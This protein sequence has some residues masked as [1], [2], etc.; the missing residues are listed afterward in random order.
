V[1]PKGELPTR[2]SP[3]ALVAPRSKVV[4][5]ATPK[6]ACT[7]IKKM[8]ADAEGTHRPEMADR[9]AIMHVS[10]AQTI[11]HPAVHGLQRLVDLPEREQREILASPEWVHIAGLRDPVSRA[12]SAWENRIF[13][14][15]HRRSPALIR[16]AHDV[17]LDGRVD[18]VASFARFAV[19][20]G[21]NADPFMADHHFL[22]QSHV[23]RSDL[24]RIDK[25]V[26]VD[27][28]GEMDALAELISH[29]SGQLVVAQRLN[30]GLGLPLRRV[31]DQHS[32]NRLMATYHA[33]YDAFGFDRRTFEQHLEPLLLGDIEQR[34][35]TAYRNAMER[36]VSAA[37]ESQRRVGARYGVKQV[38]RALQRLVRGQ[39]GRPDPREIQ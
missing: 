5:V 15:A 16:L 30:E 17:L 23:V 25:L 29:R 35:L 26:H 27:R 8:L 19:V 7:T 13:M 33:D 24:H 31:C 38:R 39:R 2:A 14:R 3:L 36:G 6:A 4:Y 11:H 20:L 28:P 1:T 21:E 22:P 32:A 12:Y 9:L 10:R 34:I 37:R 18:L